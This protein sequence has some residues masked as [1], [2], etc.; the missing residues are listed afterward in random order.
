M[1]LAVKSL[2]TNAGDTEDVRLIPGLVR[3]PGGG[4]SPIMSS[5]VRREQF[6]T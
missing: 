5:D 1:V 6:A 4:M 3:P 2:P